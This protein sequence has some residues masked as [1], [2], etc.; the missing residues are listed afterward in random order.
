MAQ[1]AAFLWLQ[2][3]FKGQKPFATSPLYKDGAVPLPAIA[4]PSFS[5]PMVLTG[6]DDTAVTQSCTHPDDKLVVQIG[7]HQSHTLT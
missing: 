4:D 6:L 5:L 7:P 2:H 1:R 3:W